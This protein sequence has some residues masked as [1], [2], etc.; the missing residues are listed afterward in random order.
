MGVPS[1]ITRPRSITTMSSAELVGLLEVLRREQQ[2][3]A[4]AD[5]LAQHVP[6][7]D[8]AA[9]VEAGRRLVEEEHRRRRD[10]ADRE[11]EPP[12]HAA[13]VGLDDP[14][15]GVREREPLEQVVGRRARIERLGRPYSRPMSR[16]FSRP[17]SS[18]STVAAW[19]VSPMRAGP[20]R[21][22]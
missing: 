20:L 19:P 18:S 9:R 21:L 12:T 7:L 4:V 17:V 13:G 1:A 16:R 11:V 22:A 2:R 6:E 3:G 10:Q 14:V 15:G 5:E 8:A